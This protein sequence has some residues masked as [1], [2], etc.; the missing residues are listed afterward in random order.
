MK[1]VKFYTFFLLVTF[2]TLLFASCYPA[3]QI[4]NNNVNELTPAL[5]EISTYL[6]NEYSTNKT[7]YSDSIK[8]A[9]IKTELAKRKIESIWLQYKSDEG[10]QYDSTIIFEWNNE[11]NDGW[12]TERVIYSFAQKK[13]AYPEINKKQLKKIQLNDSIRVEKYISRVIVTD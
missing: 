7:L 11:V 2:I 13:T 6:K 1:P 9:D 10:Q 3:I 8:N 12:I 5:T 4:S